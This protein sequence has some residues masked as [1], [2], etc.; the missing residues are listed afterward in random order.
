MAFDYYTTIIK[1]GDNVTYFSRKYNVVALIMT[2]EG[3]S[4]RLEDERGNTIEV[5]SD[6]NLDIYREYDVDELN[7]KF[8]FR[9]YDE[10]YT[11]LFKE[12]EVKEIVQNELN[13]EEFKDLMNIPYLFNERAEDLIDRYYL[14][15]QRD[16]EWL[17]RKVR[18]IV[19][20]FDV[21]NKD[22]VYKIKWD[23]EDKISSNIEIQVGW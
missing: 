20:L 8:S 18:V 3:M 17:G 13:E 23:I 6:E 4:Y 7:S 10:G 5:D 1:P 16:P 19:D 14:T 15:I 2:D 9:D 22:F 12:D 11:G 21:E